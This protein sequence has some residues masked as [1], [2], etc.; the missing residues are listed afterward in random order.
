[1]RGEQKSAEGV[2]VIG[3]CDEGPK[4]MSGLRT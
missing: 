4:V 1:M 3:V 2:V